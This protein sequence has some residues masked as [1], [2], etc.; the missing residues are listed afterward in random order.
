MNALVIGYLMISG[1]ALLVVIV[2]ML[3]SNGECYYCG[4]RLEHSE[5]LKIN[6][7]K[8]CGKCHHW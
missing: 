3:T 2:L 8:W 7:K 1:G 5:P 6:G 4:D